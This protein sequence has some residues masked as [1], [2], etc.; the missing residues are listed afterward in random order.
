MTFIQEIK[1]RWVAKSPALF[2][3][4][5]KL[6]LRIGVSAFGILTMNSVLNLTQYGVPSIIF[7]ACGYILVWCA[8]M[9]L[10]SKIT[11]E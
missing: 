10:T 1:A 9:G 7:T 3:K 2:E 4:I 8:A 11:K 5:T 6:S